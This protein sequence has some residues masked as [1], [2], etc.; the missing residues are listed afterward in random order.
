MNI[1]Y[2]GAN[3]VERD[4]L[5]VTLALTQRHQIEYDLKDVGKAPIPP[6]VGTVVRVIQ[7][8][9]EHPEWPCQ[10]LVFWEGGDFVPDLTRWE[11]P[12]WLEPA[13]EY[14]C[15]GFPLFSVETDGYGHLVV[16]N[17]EGTEV[18]SVALD[19][20]DERRDQA[21][22]DGVTRAVAGWW[23]KQNYTLAGK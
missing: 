2:K 19:L 6:I 18:N 1:S 14:G 20:D 17:P 16:R 21:F 5:A 22:F 15:D 4:A 9:V 10:L 12:T 23:R 11:L 3:V 8:P 13:Y 7:P